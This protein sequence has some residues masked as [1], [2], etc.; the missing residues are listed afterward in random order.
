MEPANHASQK[1]FELDVS[2]CSTINELENMINEMKGT[3]ALYGDAIAWTAR[4]DFYSNN[5]EYEEAIQAFQKA[6]EGDQTNYVTLKKWG[7]VLF[8]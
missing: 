8:G 2:K 1:Y 4:G 7:N 3:E 6:M 5:Q